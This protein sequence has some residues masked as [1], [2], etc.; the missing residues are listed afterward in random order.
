M[1]SLSPQGDVESLRGFFFRDKFTLKN[2]SNWIHDLDQYFMDKDIDIHPIAGEC[3][4]AQDRDTD[5][6]HPNKESRK[7]VAPLNIHDILQGVEPYLPRRRQSKGQENHSRLTQTRV[8]QCLILK[9][10][11]SVGSALGQIRNKRER[12][13]LGECDRCI[14][15]RSG[16]RPDFLNRFE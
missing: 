14:V 3:I 11:Y 15:R 10:T 7:G 6:E 16:L 1:E 2:R 12:V 4:I 8:I 13:E 5:F 9:G